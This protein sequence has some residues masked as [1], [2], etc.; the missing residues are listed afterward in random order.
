MEERQ[1]TA[2]V[3]G[4]H[5]L[6]APVIVAPPRTT[7]G[8][9]YPLRRRTRP[10]WPA[11]DG[12]PGPTPRSTCWR[13]HARA[14]RW[15]AGPGDAPPRSPA[16]A[17]GGESTPRARQGVRVAWR[18]PAAA[19]TCD[20]C[21][22]R[23][24]NSNICGRQGPRRAGRSRPSDDGRREGMLQTVFAHRLCCPV[25]R[26]DWRGGRTEEVLG[27]WARRSR[28]REASEEGPSVPRCSTRCA[29]HCRADRA[30]P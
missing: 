19:R 7:N 2:L 17:I 8:G 24:R 1:V 20:G 26:P 14:R 3:G 12:Y 22:A 10:V 29:R 18:A 21:V 9:N 30:W 11:V 28:V 23:G 27:R 5:H 15:T 13:R 6:Q 4:T 25:R 16:I